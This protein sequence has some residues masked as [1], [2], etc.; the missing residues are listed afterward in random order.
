MKIIF[1]GH[2]VRRMF[3]RAVSL[4]EVHAVLADGETIEEY[5][6]VMTY[7]SRLVLGWVDGRPLHVVAADNEGDDEIIVVTAY[8]PDPAAWDEDFLRRK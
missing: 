3:E 7:L 2:A 5:V 8:E 4:D 1:R 6:D